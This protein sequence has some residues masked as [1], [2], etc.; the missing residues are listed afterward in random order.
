MGKVAVPTCPPANVSKLAVP[1]NP[2]RTRWYT[3]TERPTTVNDVEGNSMGVVPLTTNSQSSCDGCQA[4]FVNP[5][6]VT[7]PDR[8]WADW[9]ASRPGS[10]P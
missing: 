5:A 7:V 8:A 9:C 3:A 1:S 10:T 4:N 2:S 6:L